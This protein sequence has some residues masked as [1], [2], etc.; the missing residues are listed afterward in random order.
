MTDEFSLA[1][2]S[3]LDWSIV[4]RFKNLADLNLRRLRDRIRE[5][6]ATTDSILLSE[7]LRRFPVT[8]GALE[9]IGYLVIATQEDPHYV[10]KDQFTN[11]Q[12]TE[13]MRGTTWRVP[14]VLF[15]RLG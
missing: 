9:I 11:I 7:I 13:G 3:I 5:C 12:V 2:D 8:E 15:A 4:N 14:E 1:T 6:L 10:A